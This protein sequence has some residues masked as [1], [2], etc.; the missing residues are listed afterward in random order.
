MGAGSS[1]PRIEAATGTS[2]RSPPTD[3][4]QPNVCLSGRA[5]S[6][7]SRSCAD[8][9]LLFPEIDPRTGRDLWM[10][11]P[12]GKARRCGSRR[13]M[14]RAG[15]FSPGPE[16]AP[17][18]LAY[19]SDETGAKRDLRAVVSRRGEQG[20]GLE[21]RRDDA[22]VVAGR[23]GTL[24]CDRRRI[25][26]GRDAAGS[27]P[28]ARRT[29]CSTDRGSSST[30]ASTVTVCPDGKRFLMIQR[31]PGSVPRQLNVILNWADDIGRP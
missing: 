22:R 27:D 21:R 24:L 30:T 13:S 1:S 17:R 31:D 7:H 23:Q 26:R 12:D 3:R 28:S 16:G 29:A 8:G 5:I 19:S 18:L 20:P 6:F 14:K 9:T 15:Q 2:T 11:S 25:G 10:L 4:G